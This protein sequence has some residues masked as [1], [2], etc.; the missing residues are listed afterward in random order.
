MKH[1]ELV[2]KLVKPAEEIA[3]EL[4]ASDCHLIHMTMGISGE[5]GELLDAIKKKVIYQKSLDIVNVIE[6]L[7]DLEFYMEGLRQ[8]LNITREECIKRNIEKL[9]VRYKELQYSNEAAQKRKDKTICCPKC[10][11]HNFIKRHHEATFALPECDYL[12]CSYCNTQ[13]NHA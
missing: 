9:S 7:G 12:E 5:A 2:A 4:S 1:P 13:F 11:S 10:G 6:E 8:E 3:N